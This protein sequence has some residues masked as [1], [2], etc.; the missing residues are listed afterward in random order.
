MGR[1]RSKSATAAARAALAACNSR[2]A[3]LGI[4]AAGVRLSLFSTMVDSVLSHGAEVWAVQLV[5]AAAA[6][7]PRGGTCGSGSAAEALHLGHL[8][9]L[10]GVRQATPNGAVLLE[11]GERPLWVR[12]LV[13]AG[14]LWNRLTA[15]PPGSLLERAFAASRQLA[16]GAPADLQPGRRPWAAHLAD[17][18]AAVGMPVDLEHPQPLCVKRL[19]QRALQRHLAEIS[20]AAACPGATKLAHYLT[21]AW[22]GRLPPADDYTPAP[23]AYLGAVRQ[24]VRRAALAQLRTGSHWLAEETGRW[25]QRPRELRTCPHCQEGVEDLLHALFVCPLYGQVRAR[26]LDLFAMTA[27]SLFEFMGQDPVLLSAL[28]TELQRAHSAAAI[29]GTEAAAGGG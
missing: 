24:R 20:T 4:V 16:A 8:R 28:A 22:G 1:P 12:W 15:E 27:P 26:F 14:R 9:R 29:P 19:K 11:T 10:L 21:A 6:G 2:C 3:A 5:A 23:A 13:R 25:E 17:A 18:L 7:S